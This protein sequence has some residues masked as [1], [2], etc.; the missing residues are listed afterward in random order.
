M[1]FPQTLCF[2]ST[3]KNS[4]C[5]FTLVLWAVSL[6]NDV[7]YVLMVYSRRLH[8]TVEPLGDGV[9]KW[10]SFLFLRHCCFHLFV[11]VLELYVFLIKTQCLNMLIKHSDIHFS[12]MLENYH[13]KY[14]FFDSF[15]QEKLPSGENIY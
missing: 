10:L 4:V 8:H 11:N 14:S 2:S 15:I 1:N 9:F 7:L 12:E 3:N 13:F 6:I 5:D